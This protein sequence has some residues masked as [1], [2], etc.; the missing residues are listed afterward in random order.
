MVNTCAWIGLYFLYKYANS[1]YIFRVT[2]N[3]TYTTHIASSSPLTLHLQRIDK[4]PAG[5][6]NPSG[7]QLT[8][9]GVRGKRGRVVRVARGSL[10][11]RSTP[12]AGVCEK[13]AQNS[14]S[15]D[16]LPS[17][18]IFSSLFVYG[19]QVEPQLISMCNT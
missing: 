16:F 7:I 4:N 2:H 1:I 15:I 19:V 18:N 6:R 9:P 5:N 17:G 12:R 14:A 11:T 3:C 10:D 13:R 8:H